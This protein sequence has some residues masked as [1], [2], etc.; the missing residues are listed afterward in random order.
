VTVLDA[1]RLAAT[2][3]ASAGIDSAEH[4]AEQ[5][6]RHVLG[7]DRAR[8]LA[9]G[10]AP[11]PEDAR[12]RYVTLVD[13]RSRRKPL[14]H[15]TGIQAFWKHDFEVGPDVLVPR[16]DTEVLVEAALEQLKPIERPVVVDVGTGS[17]CIALSLAAERPEAEVHA[18][19]ISK[20]ALRVARKNA[21]RLALEG[22]VTFHHGDLLAPVA[23]RAGEADLIV[24]N[25]PYVSAEEHAA[26]APEVS[27]HE[28]RLA[29]VPPHDRLSLYRRLA[30]AAAELLRPGGALAVEIGQG[31]EA[32]V[33]RVIEE[34]GL[35]PG[36]VLPDLAGIIRVV[37]AHRAVG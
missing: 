33:S 27:R 37:V 13:E 7:W 28:P 24:S 25:P 4:D 30:P 8:L 6:I 26:L 2:R 15:L 16:P 19:D 23:S 21:E 5:L 14:Q 31:M 20:P 34:A 3:L 1:L 10:A 11:L 32:E 17:G 29:L 35:L 12:S 18:V 9:D 22:H 36:R